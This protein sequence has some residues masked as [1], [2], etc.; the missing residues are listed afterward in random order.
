MTPNHLTEEGSAMAQE[1][2]LA[3]K[4]GRVS[5][6]PKPKTEDPEELIYLLRDGEGSESVPCQ[7]R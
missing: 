2:T 1:I 4:P 6:F 7:R 5:V 3:R